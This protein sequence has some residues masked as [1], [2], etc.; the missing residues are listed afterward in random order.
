MARLQPSRETR[1]H[2]DGRGHGGH[3]QVAAR[4]AFF[5]LEQLLQHLVLVQHAVG[6]RQHRL[7]LVRE[8]GVS[9][10]A[11]DD[12]H[13]E[14]GLQRAQRVRQRR[15]RDVAGLRGA[16]EVAVLVQRPEIA[17]RREQ[18]HA[19]LDQVFLLTVMVGNLAEKSLAFSAMPT[20]TRRA[21]DL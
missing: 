3:A 6:R 17:H 19:A 21:T 4:L 7:A 1:Q 16:T 12:D 5:A 18:V 20:A 10:P 2:R 14:L 13:A 9:A 11:L 15:L 8:P